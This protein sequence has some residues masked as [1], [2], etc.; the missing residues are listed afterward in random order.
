MAEMN[1]LLNMPKRRSTEEELQTAPREPKS[2]TVFPSQLNTEENIIALRR[3]L[4]QYEA[5]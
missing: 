4:G 3:L 1:P 2:E 5:N